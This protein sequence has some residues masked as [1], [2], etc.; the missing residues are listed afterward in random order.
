LQSATADGELESLRVRIAETE[1]RL[2]RAREEELN[3]RM[4][5]MTRFV[6]VMDILK[7]YFKKEFQTL[8]SSPF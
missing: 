6:L 7:F 8:A 3:R 1:I 5:Q 2:E 4:E